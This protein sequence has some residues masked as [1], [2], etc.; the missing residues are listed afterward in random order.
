MGEQ[1][2]SGS[3]SKTVQVH[4]LLVGQKNVRQQ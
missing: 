2:S 1:A 3:S 4:K